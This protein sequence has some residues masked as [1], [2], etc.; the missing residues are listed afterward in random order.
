MPF[1]LRILP[2]FRPGIAYYLDRLYL[3]PTNRSPAKKT[4]RD[5]RGPHFVMREGSGFE[6]AVPRP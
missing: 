4:M 5:C 1:N 6:V 2:C 3:A